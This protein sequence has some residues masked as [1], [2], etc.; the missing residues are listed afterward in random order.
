MSDLQVVARHRSVSQLTTYAACG[1]RYN[2]ERVERAP[3][4]PAAWTVQGVSF[5]TAIEEYE[6]SGRTMSSREV[7][8]VF[9][10]SWEKGIAD[11]KSREPNLSKWLRGGR[12]TTERDISDRLT[13]GLQQVDDYILYVESSHDRIATMPDGTP[14]IEVG[15]RLDL[16]GVEVVGYIDQIVEDRYGNLKVRDLKTGN[17]PVW[18]VQLGVYRLAMLDALSVDIQY[19]DYYLAKKQET[20]K[21]VDLRKLYPRDKVTKMFQSLDKGFRSGIFI[22]NPGNCF[23]CSVKHSCW[24]QV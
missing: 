6:K 7:E 14:A 13:L 19:G 1:E 9:R 23:T 8:D 11:G 15:F 3:Q 12:K 24:A 22:P 10:E 17:E 2:L 21:P 4:L 5:H 20:T 16:G 18:P